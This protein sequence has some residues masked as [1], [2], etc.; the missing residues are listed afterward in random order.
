[1]TM[2]ECCLLNCW[3]VVCFEGCCSLA[4]E[5]P[6]EKAL[7]RQLGRPLRGYLQPALPGSLLAYLRRWV[8]SLVVH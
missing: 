2:M 5:T 6:L 1:M 4:M 3:L 8:K 7:E